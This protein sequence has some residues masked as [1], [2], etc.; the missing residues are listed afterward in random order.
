MDDE[1]DEYAAFNDFESLTEEDFARLDAT[2]ESSQ[3]HPTPTHFTA[4]DGGSTN[5]LAHA[6]TSAIPYM[7]I[8]LEDTEWFGF[9]ANE[10]EGSP[11][12][13]HRGKRPLA[14]TDILSLAWCEVQFDY[15]M[16]Q[17]R[18][19]KL[20]DRPALFRAE[21]GKEIVVQ[22]EVAARND[23]TTKRGQF[24][25][26][27]LERELRPEEIKVLITSKEERWALRLI[28]FLSSMV[29]LG[30]EGRVR[31]VPVFGI[32]DGIVVV[33]IIDELLVHDVEPEVGTKRPSE[34]SSPSPKRPCRASSAPPCETNPGPASSPQRLRVIDTKT[35]RTYSLPS[36]E[37]AEPAWLQ[38]ML[39]RRL[40]TSLLDSSEQFDFPTLWASAGVNPSASF[41][42]EFKQQA[43]QA[44]GNNVPACL[45]EL[46]LVMR[47]RLVDLHLPQL[48][49]TL[50]I[51]YRSQNKYPRRSDKGKRRADT[52]ENNQ[53]AE[54]INM[55]LEDFFQA[56]LA[57][58]LKESAA[59]ANA[60]VSDIHASTSCAS[61]AGAPPASPNS[62][63]R[64]PLVDLNVNAPPTPSPETP[65]SRPD[66]IGT[67]EF[68]MDDGVLDAYLRNALDWWRGK[69]PARGV[70]DSQ[71]G[72]CFSCEY[73]D[74]CEWREKKASEKLAAT[75]ARRALREA[76]PT[77]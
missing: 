61:P 52:G 4:L 64:E 14:V 39:Y 5:V 40:L 68:V 25:H 10:D 34:E 65:P 69:R 43:A 22:Q 16:R 30:A 42:P 63:S 55:S 70:S 11:I 1:D 35:R 74:G 71:T 33:G 13:R 45:D 26:K 62:A 77:W 20:A 21:S 3:V 67:K 19:R 7:A 58:A 73:M 27:E 31:E 17:K 57:A 36:D 44:L 29:S 59:L 51:I 23:K 56:Q 38:V 6:S 46:V 37:D 32:L 12:R 15:G 28:D 60:P 50:Q 8:E 48:D 76:T 75:R 18:F 47:T 24:I 53:I 2:T 66:I 72:R 41:S 54:A 49:D 9:H